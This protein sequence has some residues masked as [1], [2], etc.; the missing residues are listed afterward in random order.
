MPLHPLGT[1]GRCA[2]GRGQGQGDSPDVGRERSEHSL[3]R[4]GGGLGWGRCFSL[5]QS[6]LERTTPTQPSPNLGEGVI[7]RVQLLHQFT[8]F[9][10]PSGWRQAVPVP[11]WLWPLAETPVW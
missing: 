7:E 2:E 1:Q 8:S 11:L 3:P 5:A 4:A 9:H 10:V 6:S